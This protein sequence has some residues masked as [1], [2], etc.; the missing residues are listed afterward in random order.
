M[1]HRNLADGSLYFGALF[2]GLVLNMFNGIS[3]IA[4][5]IEKLPVFYKQRDFMFYPAWAYSLPICITEIPLSII[6]ST[7]WVSLTY[8]T[9]DFAPG[10]DRYVNLRRL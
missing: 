7:A 5:T 2:L 4:T 10:T 9:I 3:G 6:E 8:Y 1:H